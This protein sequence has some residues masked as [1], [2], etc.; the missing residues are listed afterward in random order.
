MRKVW[1]VVALLAVVG[2]IF[3]AIV[4]ATYSDLVAKRNAVTITAL[5]NI[6]AAE[7]RRLDTIPNFA[8]N[9]Q[10]SK[11][12]QLQ[13]QET[14]VQGREGVKSAVASGD[15]AALQ[16]AA[17]DACGAM[18]I[19]VRAEAVPEA[20]LDQ[21]TELNAQ[22]ENVER[23]IQHERAAFNKTDEIYMTAKQKPLA[24]ML[25]SLFGWGDT[26]PD[27]QPFKADP[28]AKKSPSYDLK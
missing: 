10:F 6:E 11:D 13:L 23:V 9:A 4:Y 27:I 18:L 1:I 16:K 15:T 2:L 5:P 26:F 19:A 14:N 12:F 25:I 3:G 8:K 21:I 28:G 17:N 7:Q 20:K 22:I 24:A